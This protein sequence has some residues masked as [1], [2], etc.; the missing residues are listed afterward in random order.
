V[1]RALRLKDIA[2]AIPEQRRV[3]LDF[4][5]A[6]PFGPLGRP[7]DMIERLEENKCEQSRLMTAVEYNSKHKRVHSKFLLSRLFFFCPKIKI[8]LLS[9]LKKQLQV[10]SILLFK[11]SEF[12]N[13]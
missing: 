9:A 5:R 13:K 11:L 7:K 8:R 6:G 1:A 2:L 4:P 3:R 10:L 12:V